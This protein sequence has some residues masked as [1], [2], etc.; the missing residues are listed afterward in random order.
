M[1]EKKKRLSIYMTKVESVIVGSLAHN[2]KAYWYGT[3]LFLSPF[4]FTMVSA[5]IYIAKV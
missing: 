4:V 2:I 5:Q 1:C 3:A